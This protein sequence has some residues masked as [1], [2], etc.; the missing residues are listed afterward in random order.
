ML[1]WCLTFTG[2]FKTTTVFSLKTIQLIGTEGTRLLRKSAAKGDPTGAKSAEEAPGP[3][4]ESECLEWKST[5]FEVHSDI[6]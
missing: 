6:P 1:V 2:Q 3:P 4:A 5:L